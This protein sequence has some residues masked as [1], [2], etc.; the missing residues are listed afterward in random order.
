[1]YSITMLD[2]IRSW[3]KRLVHYHPCFV[4][5]IE[6]DFVRQQML[7]KY[8]N[9]CFNSEIIKDRSFVTD[10][11]EGE[12]F[13]FISNTNKTLR[14]SQIEHLMVRS[15]LDNDNRLLSSMIDRSIDVLKKLGVLSS[16]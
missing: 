11:T 9:R 8:E 2:Y 3:I 14:Q 6:E 13:Q 12:I 10:A 1:M 4:E 5:S 15:K 16:F 7:R